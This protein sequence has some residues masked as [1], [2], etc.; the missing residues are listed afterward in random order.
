[1]H[2]LSIDL[3]YSFL[4]AQPYYGKMHRH[5]LTV[6]SQR[7]L[8]LKIGFAIVDYTVVISMDYTVKIREWLRLLAAECY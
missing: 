2:K 5:L 7:M 8:A 1:M 3:F 4:P 6:P